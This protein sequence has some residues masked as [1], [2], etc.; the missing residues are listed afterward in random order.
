M[1]LVEV[2]S[3]QSVYCLEA[4]NTLPCRRSESFGY[5]P[6]KLYILDSAHEAGF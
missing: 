3:V 1:G 2:L 4:E 5:K 6:M